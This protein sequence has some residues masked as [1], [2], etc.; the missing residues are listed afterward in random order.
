MFDISQP[1]H[2]IQRLANSF[3]DMLPRFL[4]AALIAWGFVF[5][6]RM[7]RKL[8]E[9]GAA[10]KREH[11]TL[12]LA[13]GRVV[14]AGIAIVGLLVAATAAFPTFTVGTL[15]STL[16]IGGVAIGFAFKDIFQNFLAGILLLVTKPFN[17]G[18]QI[19]FKD[20]EGTVEDIQTRATLLKTYD[21]RRVVIPNSDLYM[22]AV[23]VNTAFETR[24]VEHDFGIS[25][26]DD[27]AHAKA[28]MI[29]AMQNVEGVL[30]DPAADVLVIGISDGVVTLRSR[31]WANSRV[32]DALL[33]QDQVLTGIKAGLSAAGI[34]LAGAGEESSVTT[35][36]V[37]ATDTEGTASEN[38]DGEAGRWTTGDGR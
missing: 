27:V 16:G 35:E 5:L 29:D 2:T 19:I 1:W 34:R 8:V 9:R 18:D 13:L 37:A 36:P 17:V 4:L 23:T 26:E 12:Q 11:R 21:G 20:F 25:A 15:V 14:Q 7:V 30:Q 10:A 28:I 31:W 38:P 6:G 3:L 22:N 24:R 32:P 33:A